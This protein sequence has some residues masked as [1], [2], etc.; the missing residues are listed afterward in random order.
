MKT[1][2]ENENL[3]PVFVS[4]GYDIY[5][6]SEPLYWTD[7]LTINPDGTVDYEE[8]L[9]DM[10]KEFRDDGT[11]DD[12]PS[13]RRDYLDENEDLDLSDFSEAGVSKHIMSFSESAQS[14]PHLSS[15]T[16]NI[17]FA[18]IS[19]LDEMPKSQINENVLI[20]AAINAGHFSSMQTD[21]SFSEDLISDLPNDRE[22]YSSLFSDFNQS[23][24]ITLR[25]LGYQE[26]RE[27][28]Q[29]GIRAAKMY[30]DAYPDATPP[31]IVHMTRLATGLQ[32]ED[33][34]KTAIRIKIGKVNYRELPEASMLSHLSF[35]E[36]QQK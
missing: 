33:L 7:G 18:L 28:L 14:S 36:A 3:F 17:N 26:T 9:E 19:Y 5:G 16:N 12:A 24:N 13:K 31:E 32:K 11:D 21:P 22:I 10:L 23:R 35:M 27:S 29:E 2:V 6:L 1:I 20:T 30:V 8:D 15:I 4:L 25:A 34:A